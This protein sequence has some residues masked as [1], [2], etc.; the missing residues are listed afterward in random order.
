MQ[1]CWY[2]SLL[3]LEM[4]IVMQ[5]IRIKRLATFYQWAEGS[6]EAVKAGSRAL[7]IYNAA[8]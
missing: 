7:H 8:A 4:V 3:H 2:I 6:G 5:P 1:N